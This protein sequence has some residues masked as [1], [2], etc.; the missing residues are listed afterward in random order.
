VVI[1]VGALTPGMLREV[2]EALK[3]AMDMD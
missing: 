2:E 3:A 1:E